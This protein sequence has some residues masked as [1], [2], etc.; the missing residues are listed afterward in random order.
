[1]QQAM[2][3]EFVYAFYKGYR[4]LTKMLADNSPDR[5]GREGTGRTI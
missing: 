5:Q 1:M 3:R 2:V 4:R